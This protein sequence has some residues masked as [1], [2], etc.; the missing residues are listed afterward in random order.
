[1][2]ICEVQEYSDLTYRV[3]DYGRVD[4]QGKPRELHT[5]KALEV[6]QFGGSPVFPFQWPNP[7][8]EFGTA[9]IN[10][11][12]A[13]RY[14]AVERWELDGETASA[15]TDAARFE[16]L[17]ILSGSGQIRW[18]AGEH[19]Y[20]AGEIWL[21]PASLGNYRLHSTRE[22]SNILRTYVPDLM[23]FEKMIADKGYSDEDRRRFIFP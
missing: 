7:M 12:C 2:V 19:K 8:D 20:S 1:M 18:R 15:S 23:A 9:Y 16:L 5:A 3:Y 17:I 22:D 6:I 4:A 10:Y 14:F 11:L 13:C 21:L